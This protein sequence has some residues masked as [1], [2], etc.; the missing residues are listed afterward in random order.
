MKLQGDYE[1]K[2]ASEDFKVNEQEE[3]KENRNRGRDKEGHL[4]KKIK[5]RY[6]Q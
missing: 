4:K 5:K 3:N 2:D 1:R 6:K